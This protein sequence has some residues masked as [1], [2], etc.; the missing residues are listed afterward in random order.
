MKMH[1]R[2]ITT[3]LLSFLLL[4]VLF[5][6]KIFASEAQ[7]LLAKSANEFSNFSISCQADKVL[8]NQWLSKYLSDFLDPE[9][10]TNL[11]AA[12][13]NFFHRSKRFQEEYWRQHLKQ[14]KVIA[15]ENIQAMPAFFYRNRELNS[16]EMNLLVAELKLLISNGRK[17]SATFRLLDE[18]GAK[19]KYGCLLSVCGMGECFFDDS[20]FVR[21]MSYIASLLAPAFTLIGIFAMPTHQ[22]CPTGA[23]ENITESNTTEHLTCWNQTN[24]LQLNPTSYIDR[25]DQ[26]AVIS[27]FGTAS[28]IIVCGYIT[29]CILHCKKLW[30]DR[31]YRNFWHKIE[32]LRDESRKIL[33]RCRI[34]FLIESSD[35]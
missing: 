21:A 11:Q 15:R 29:A 16:E 12:S 23:Y 25:S 27:I 9:S 14:L 7:P 17:I 30:H 8:A 10:F 4:F 2:R 35:A 20:Y 28:V 19:P 31:K 26:L 22:R 3:R 1:T 13:R 6:Q 34:Y 33:K 24:G 18:L 5:N 32:T